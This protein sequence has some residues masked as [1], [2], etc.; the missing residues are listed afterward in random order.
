MK[1]MSDVKQWNPGC[2]PCPTLLKFEKCSPAALLQISDKEG[3]RVAVEILQ[4]AIEEIFFPYPF[5]GINNTPVWTSRN[6]LY[7][8]FCP[9]ATSGGWYLSHELFLERDQLVTKELHSLCCSS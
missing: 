7:V 6:G 1:M 2:E 5:G 8:F 9:S 4:Q 3:G